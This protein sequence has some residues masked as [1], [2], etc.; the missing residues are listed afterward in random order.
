MGFVKINDSILTAIGNAI[1]SKLGVATTYKPSQMPDAISSIEAAALET[2]SITANGTYT[3][4]SGKNG[5]S[6]VTVAVDNTYTAEDEG[7]VV[8]NGILVSQTSTTK[9][10]NGTYN[11]MLNNEVIVAIPLA[12]GVSF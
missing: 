4:S 2:K 6:S 3:P 8:D 7:K 12:N 11:T 1:R 9:T 10:A 5:F